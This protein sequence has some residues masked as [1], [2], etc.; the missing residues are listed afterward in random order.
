MQ[1]NRRIHPA[2]R[3]PVGDAARH[4]PRQIGQADRRQG[5][6]PRHQRHGGIKGDHRGAARQ[7]RQHLQ[8]QGQIGLAR[9]QIGQPL[10]AT[11]QR[12][13]QPRQHLT[14]GGI[15]QDQAERPVALHH[16]L[17]AVA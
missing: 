17:N 12:K 14:I 6:A 4:H 1:H 3:L 15:G 7:A 5:V 2:Q 16:M 9:L 8:R 11:L 13:P 10:I